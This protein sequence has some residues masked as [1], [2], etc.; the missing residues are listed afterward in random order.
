MKLSK[1]FLQTFKEV[2]NDA[3]IISHQLLHRAGYIQKSGAGLYNY[4]PMMLKVIS[5][6]ENIIRNALNKRDCLE[7]HLST[8][9]TSELWKESGRWDEMGDIMLTFKDRLDRE[10]CFSPTNEEAVVDYF[11]KIAKSYKQLPVCLYQ[12]NTKFRD[13]IR[14]RFGLMRAR[15]FSMKDAY[16]FH[17]SKDCLNKTYDHMYAAYSEIFEA[18]NLNYIVVEADPGDMAEAGA[19]THEFQV[20]A[21]SGEDCVVVCEKDHYAANIEFAQSK[22]QSG[23]T[24]SITDEALTEIE[25][26]NAKTIEEICALLSIEAD[27]A[28]KTLLYTFIKDDKKQF[29]LVCCL[30]DDDVNELKVKK[31]VD[32]TSLELAS[33]EDCAQINA[34][35]GFLGPIGFSE[36]I[37][38]IIDSQI[39]RSAG[40][41]VG[42]NKKDFHLKSLVFSR[43]VP[44]AVVEDIRLTKETDLSINGNPIVFK[45]G[46]EVGHI[47]QLGTKYSKA[48]NASILDQNGKTTF[49]EMGCYGIGVGRTIAATIEQLHDEK[50]IVWPKS[51][52]PYHVIIMNLNHKDELCCNTA[53]DLYRYCLKNGIE[54]L[55]DDR[56]V[57]AGVKFKDADLLGIPYQVI[58]GKTFKE[59][60]MLE[61]NIRQESVKEMMHI[62][63]VMKRI[64]VDCQS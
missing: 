62:D 44:N 55:Y 31:Y 61:Y 46:I 15:E 12:I 53:N 3:Q 14:P 19:K 39:N 17:E 29:L 63:D 23:S 25:T 41:V 51:I 64:L 1:L 16:S 24:A 20:I 56:S 22:R 27:Q 42:A 38:I 18:L 7:V 34:V 11:R 13:E 54:V 52:A 10:L 50:G 21:N 59:R 33:V 60:Q 45:R 35:Q 32:G 6:M 36:D 43:D 5:K 9:T 28:V 8:L 30:G 57:T 47:F 37:T 2:P 49:P 26:P 58:I 4:S 48:L 40:Y